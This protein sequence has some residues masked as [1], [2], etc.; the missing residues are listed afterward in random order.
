MSTA[1]TIIGTNGK[2]I[3]DSTELKVFF[4]TSDTPKGYSKGWNIKQINQ[5]SNDVNFY[6]RGEEYSSQIDYFIDT[7]EGNKPNNVNTFESAWI[8]DN[9]IE[10]IKKFKNN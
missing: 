4:K 5:L 3:V 1:I 9:V 8:T 10:Q 7:L 6:L 2:L